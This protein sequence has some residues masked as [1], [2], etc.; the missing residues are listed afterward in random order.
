MQ[1]GVEINECKVAILIEDQEKQNT[2]Y[3]EPHPLP[4]LQ[5]ISR[6]LLAS[7]KYDR[8]NQERNSNKNR[9]PGGIESQ[10]GEQD[11]RRPQARRQEPKDADR[12]D[13]K[14]QIGK[15]VE[16]H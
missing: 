10:A 3:A 7:K 1:H 2:A 13:E 6:D 16:L 15:R 9:A 5:R 14:H 12:H 11:E 4:G 8:S